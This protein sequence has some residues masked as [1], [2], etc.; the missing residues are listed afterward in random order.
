MSVRVVRSM[1]RRGPSERLLRAAA[2]FGLR[3]SRGGGA[4]FERR[5]GEMERT[6]RRVDRAL[7]RGR[8]ALIV[9]PS[10]A[11]KS[12]LLRALARRLGSRALLLDDMLR[13]A[14]RGTALADAGG[15]SLNSWLECLARAGLAEAGLLALPIASLSDGQRWRAKLAGA[16]A[17]S[18]RAPGCTI[19][20]DE[21]T[22]LLDRV[23]GQSVARTLGRWARSQP[24]ARVVAATAHDDI[25]ESL[26]PDLVV[27]VPLDAP[28]E[29]LTG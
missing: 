3:V 16:M 22:S 27:H 8:V 12:L 11:G 17:R 26:A 24:R 13:D 18:S 15:G 25:L 7:L 23:T 6:A 19:M 10:G 21:F 14:E 28:P 5:R 9:G 20:I 4:S 29:V 2:M 1:T